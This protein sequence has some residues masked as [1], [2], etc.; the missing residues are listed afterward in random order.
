MQPKVR[1]LGATLA[2][3]AAALA[4]SSGALAGGSAN[5]G[6]RGQQLQGELL[7]SSDPDCLLKQKA[8]NKATVSQTGTA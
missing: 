5:A 8:K 6:R 7:A 4:L 1:L 3:V 2:T